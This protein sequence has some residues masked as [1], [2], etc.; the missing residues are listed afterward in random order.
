MKD[1][2][3][4][5]AVAF[6]RKGPHVKNSS[7][8]QIDDKRKK[9][10]WKGGGLRVQKVSMVGANKGSGDRAWA[11][12]ALNLKRKGNYFFPLKRSMGHVG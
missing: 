3:M 2:H 6:Q 5:N 7:S 10:K 9:Q 12:R 4:S 11:S 8:K 1:G